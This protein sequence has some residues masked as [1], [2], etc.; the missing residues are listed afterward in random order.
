MLTSM[1]PF[2][3]ITCCSQPGRGVR[4]MRRKVDFPAGQLTPSTHPRGQKVDERHKDQSSGL[5]C[6]QSPE[7]VLLNINGFI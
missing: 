7:T 1:C 6:P 2:G 3:R 5:A 4:F